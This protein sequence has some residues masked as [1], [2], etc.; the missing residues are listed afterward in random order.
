[1]AKIKGVSNSKHTMNIIFISLQIINNNS[2]KSCNNYLTFVIT[3][4]ETEIST[5]YRISYDKCLE[6]QKF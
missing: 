2:K 4:Y 3:I 1:M 5:F 6:I